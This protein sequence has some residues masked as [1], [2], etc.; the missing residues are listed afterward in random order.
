MY[1]EHADFF[2]STGQTI[3]HLTYTELF[4]AVMRPEKPEGTEE[5]F[6]NMAL[7][8]PNLHTLETH[9]VPWKEGGLREML[10]R[11]E[12]IKHLK[13]NFA[14]KVDMLA[15]NEC[16]HIETLEMHYYEA[17]MKKD[18][19]R[20]RRFHH[21][22]DYVPQR[23]KDTHTLRKLIFF[24]PSMDCNLEF[25][26]N[27]I[28]ANKGL[29]ELYVDRLGYYDMT[30]AAY[31]CK[32]LT[33]LRANLSLHELDGPLDDEEDLPNI[34]DNT[35]NVRYLQ[36]SS[37]QSEMDLLTD[38]QVLLV[39]R[40]CPQYVVLVLF[41]M[42]TELWLNDEYPLPVPVQTASPSVSGLQTLHVRTMKLPVLRKVI[43]LCPH[44][45]ELGI[46][47]PEDLSAFVALI[48]EKKIRRLHLQ[49]PMAES[50]RPLLNLRGLEFLHLFNCTELTCELLL[51]IAMQNT[52]LQYIRI[53]DCENYCDQYLDQL[54]STCPKLHTLHVDNGSENREGVCARLKALHPHL[55]TV[56]VAHE[57]Y[58]SDEE[59]DDEDDEDDEEEDEEE[60]EEDEEIPGVD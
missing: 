27:F 5:R 15:I 50:C 33:A 45:T 41:D 36:L 39:L 37:E 20:S 34:I 35:K 2:E 10:T 40:A 49:L 31:C 48:T 57:D 58:V 51:A 13:L 56:H 28:T 38:E 21:D 46:T 32:E 47:D 12:K 1:P 52:D 25:L 22:D 60:E 8:C 43:A 6:F 44:L 3:P 17:A 24:S 16:E 29:R 59:E 23:F 18:Y 26:A 14:S 54:V 55:R 11:C 7:Q 9:E 42:R 19:S 53:F 4:A 30:F